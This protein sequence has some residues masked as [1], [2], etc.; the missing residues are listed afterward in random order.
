MADFS[1]P[2]TQL[3]EAPND[4]SFSA[5]EAIVFERLGIPFFVRQADKFLIE[6]SSKNGFFVKSSVTHLLQ[7]LPQFSP[8]FER[9]P[10]AVG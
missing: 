6:Q 9:P 5:L 3:I 2:S 4:G 8:R 1:V 7:R 10:N